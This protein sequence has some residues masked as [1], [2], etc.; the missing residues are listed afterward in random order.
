MLSCSLGIHCPELWLNTRRQDRKVNMYSGCSKS[1]T[2]YA[3]DCVTTALHRCF[4]CW[5]PSVTHA[6]LNSK[7]ESMRD[8]RKGTWCH[9]ILKQIWWR[10]DDK[11]YGYI[12]DASQ[13]LLQIPVLPIFGALDALLISGCYLG[14]PL[15]M[16]AV[17]CKLELSYRQTLT[18]GGWKKHKEKPLSFSPFMSILE[19]CVCSIPYLLM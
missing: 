17:R 4:W 1:S 19:H 15:P 10:K 7:N 16:H 2:P 14:V 18:S 11:D 12:I 5:K 8:S 9:I 13:V 6:C 3:P